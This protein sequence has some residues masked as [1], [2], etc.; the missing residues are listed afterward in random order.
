ME[1]VKHNYEE[2]LK[3]KDRNYNDMLE[4]VAKE[5]NEFR[6]KVR[7]KNAKIGSLFGHIHKMK[8]KNQRIREENE[9]QRVEYEEKLRESEIRT[10]VHLNEI[11]RLQALIEKIPNQQPPLKTTCLESF[12]STPES[13]SSDDSESQKSVI[14]GKPES[15]QSK[16]TNPNTSQATFGKPECKNS[17]L[18][19]NFVNF[20]TWV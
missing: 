7:E 5:S 17:R 2:R 19:L 10:T 6:Q 13:L 1:Q 3:L 4:Q 15:V 14:V 11:N 18:S 9:R 8:R 12:P 16:F 20:N